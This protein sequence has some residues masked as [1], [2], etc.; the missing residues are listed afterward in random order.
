MIHK[1]NFVEENLEQHQ[2]VYKIEI[3]A[4]KVKLG[5]F[6]NNKADKKD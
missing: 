1:L 2:N 4:I 6:D 5:I 3:N